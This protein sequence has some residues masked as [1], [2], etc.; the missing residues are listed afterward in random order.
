MLYSTT[1][2]GHFRVFRLLWLLALITFLV[3]PMY[4]QVAGATL[5]GTVTDSSGAAIPGSQ[6]SIKNV[7]TGVSTA[8]TANS[9][10]FYSAPNLVPGSYELS[11]SAPGFTTE[12]RSG[13]TLQ[14]GAQQVLNF[15][16][17]V[18]QTT[19]TVQVTNEAVA[20]ELGSS[21]ISAVVTSNAIVG[22]PLNG[23]DWTQLAGLEPGVSVIS[24]QRSGNDPSSPRG[25]RGFGQQLSISG[26]MP[27][28][29]NY[30]LDGVSIVDFAG[31]APGSVL[32]LA[33][34]VDA[35]AEFSVLTS[36]SS[37]EYGRTSGGVVNAVTRSGTNQFHGDAYEFLRNSAL[38]ARNF[39][40]GPMIPAFKRNQFGASLGGP[41]QKS[42]TFFFFDYEGLRDRLG[43]SNVDLVPS[44]GARNGI[45][46]NPDGT[47]C[48][49]GVASPGC[50]LVNSAGT[51]GVD[52]LV[53]PF[54]GMYPLPNAGLVGLGDTGLFVT[55]TPE[56]DHSNFET[57]RID[58]K[59]SDKDSVFGTWFL[60]RSENQQPDP[61]DN[62]LVGN[63][64][65]RLLMV[66][67]EDHTF[68]S[69]LI[70]SF[71]FGLNREITSQ[72]ANL[73]AI[74]PLV[75][76]IALS[77]V[78]G[79]PAS[80]AVSV[81]GLTDV[82]PGGVGAYTGNFFA[83]NS[84]QAY[85]DAFLLKGAHSIKFGFAVERMQENQ[86]L[87]NRQVG[88]IN[89]GSLPDFLTNQPLTYQAGVLGLDNNPRG[90]RQTLFGGYFQD[91]WRLSSS[92][93][94]NLGLRYEMVTVP[95]D[96]KNQLVSLPTFTSPPPG[97]LG[98]PFFHNPTLRNFEPR[99]GFSWDPFHS[100]KT[101]VRG[102][103]G[104]FDA[105]PLN[106]EFSNIESQSA[107]Y[108]EQISVANLPQGSFP[109]GPARSTIGTPP[110]SEELTSSIEQNPKRNYIMI[111]NL[112]VQQQL[113]P[114]TLLLVGY[115]GNRGV[116]MVNRAE[117]VNTVLP[118]QITPQ[119][120][121]WPF[122]AGSGTV[123]NPAVGQLRGL[124]WTG[125]SFF[126]ALEVRVSKRMSHGF[127]V[128]GSFTWAKNIDTGSSATIGDNFT[129]SVSSLF[130][131]CKACRRSV[132]DYNIPHALV[133][134]YLWDVPSPKNWG[135]I[136]SHVL[137][138]WE[139]GG[140]FKAQTGVPMTP[141]ISG[142]PLGLNS[143]DPWAFPDRLTG[144][145]CSNPV[146]PGN[147]NN[148][149]KLNCFAVPMATPAIAAVCTPFSA[150]PGSCA[151]LMGNAGRNS[152]IGPDLVNFDFS[153]FK[154]N[155]IKR[156]SESFNA[157][158]RAEFFNILNRANF[159]AP[160]NNSALFDSN[161]NPVA[162]AGAVN[163]TSTTSRQIQFA[164]KLI[165]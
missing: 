108:S 63:T 7:A 150:V 83:W 37:A 36:N 94:L 136:S 164:L 31:G 141:I 54:L 44:R 57:A 163:Q 162:G 39:F 80:T 93:T 159:S 5:S 149:I 23:R 49:I 40:D 88:Q 132:S 78:P 85:D 34:G 112:N 128:E 140:I 38:D 116:H 102:A 15:S 133:L 1:A 92:L 148:Y 24:T 32:G 120:L 114:S 62:V 8:A 124:Y 152:L 42:K 90:I 106:F 155:Y 91:D 17:R 110:P 118:T 20:V 113:T 73:A 55:S 158:F 72:T 74:N 52:P 129:N 61:L 4:G 151:N 165:W 68:T 96:V 10:G 29:N 107:P 137:G 131:F 146:N 84:F 59:F 101:A 135:V 3:R 25:T 77:S 126:D 9:V 95:T 145:G 26:T 125:D 143:T 89:F 154:N 53:V 157:Q 153:L 50:A 111:W 56:S 76:D 47:T 123:I 82:V 147:P 69:N 99:I 121:L 41:I 48:T 27:Q 70:N 160:I 21:S 127:Q 105:L 28:Q 130:W 16:L 45:L 13:I 104:I 65:S 19:E 87:G 18:G 138:G 100:G 79:E 119:G 115:V 144:P 161:G 58:H 109:S 60:D 67:G 134:N 46:H 139:V 156:I 98:S 11:A 117:D 43:A 33:L 35:I 22:L 103:F 97:H 14:V 71:R 122:P 2:K 12:V 86:R 75:T 66:L 6:I 142:D 81:P 51:V 30:R 64:S